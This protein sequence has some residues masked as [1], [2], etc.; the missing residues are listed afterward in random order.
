MSKRYRHY[1][2]VSFIIL[3][4][5]SSWAAQAQTS[6]VEINH[7]SLDSYAP[8]PMFEP[9]PAP[10]KPAS[11]VTIYNQDIQEQDVVEPSVQDILEQ[12]EGKKPKNKKPAPIENITVEKPK[13]QKP[14]RVHPQPAVKRGNI[15][16]IAEPNT[17]AAS[18]PEPQFEPLNYVLQL[19][20][21]INALSPEQKA[22]IRAAVLPAMNDQTAQLLIHSY[23]TGNDGSESQARRL[24]LAQALA[25]KA[26]LM[27]LDIPERRIHVLALGD[28]APIPP[29]NK[30]V[31]VTQ[32][33]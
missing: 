4:L 32:Q 23:A 17:H 19:E 14:E 20:P 21:M 29:E 11:G 12:L 3:V 25:A 6:G 28:K 16:T 33:Y 13:I 2:I 18:R 24:S 1:L 27:D 7:E 26:Y 5:A 8:P 30:L 10:Q 22:G 15:H 31:F 9:S